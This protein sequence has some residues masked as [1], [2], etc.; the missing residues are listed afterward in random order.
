MLSAVKNAVIR[1]ATHRVIK[2]YK[3]D[4]AQ[5]DPAYDGLPPALWDCGVSAAGHLTI[6]GFDSAELARTHGTP[7]HIVSHARLI[8]NYQDFIGAFRR[9]YDRCVLATSYKTNPLPGVVAALHEA[10]TWAEAISAFELWLALKLGMAPE[11]IILNGPGKGREAIDSAV[12]NGIQSINL[13]NSEEIDWTA[14]ACARHGRRQNVGIRVIVPGGWTSQ[15][16]MSIADGE[17]EAACA[18]IIGLDSL[19][20]SGLHVHLGTGIKDVDTYGRALNEVVQFGRRM[21][22]RHGVVIDYYDFGGGFAVPTVHTLDSW[23]VRML[24]MGLPPRAAFPDACPSPEAYASSITSIVKSNH[25]RAG[26]APPRIILE[27]GRAITSSAQTL[28][29]SVITVKR[30]QHRRPLLIMDAGKHL[31]MPLGWEHHQMFA[32][33]RMHDTAEGMF[34]VYGPLCHPGDVIARAKTLPPL[35]AEDLLAVMDAGA[36]FIPNQMNFSHPRAGVVMLRDGAVTS[37]RRPERF[38]DIIAL[39]SWGPVGNERS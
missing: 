36:Y 13:D 6:D 32:A 38:E 24:D 39:D 19:R 21:E 18:R 34:D 33:N 10:G 11:R 3:T 15:F 8:K 31:T 4:R 2:Q 29:M 25:D 23:D 12:A 1:A 26:S 14:N 17:A 22:D 35:V 9:H 28:L 5:L 27:P 7:L 30:A 20:M 16:G 37:I